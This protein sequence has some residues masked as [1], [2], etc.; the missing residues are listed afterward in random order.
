M[1]RN[2]YCIVETDRYRVQRETDTIMQRQADS[3][4]RSHPDFVLRRQTDTVVPTETEP[5]CGDR[6]ILQFNFRQIL[7][8]KDR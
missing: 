7:Y 3:V 5:Y 1:R 6:Q 8:G 4:V 2:K